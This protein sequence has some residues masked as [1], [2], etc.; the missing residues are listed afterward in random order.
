MATCDILSNCLPPTVRPSQSR[1]SS[2]FSPATRLLH[3]VTHLFT[4]HKGGKIAARSPSHARPRPRSPSRYAVAI[5]I[6]CLPSLLA[7]AAAAFTY[8]SKAERG[9]RV[10]SAHI[11]LARSLFPSNLRNLNL[12]GP[13][14][15]I[16]PSR[17]ALS[18]SLS[19][20]LLRSKLIALS[21]K[22]DTVNG[23]AGAGGRPSKQVH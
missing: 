18:L 9:L 1:P 3:T 19:P 15:M 6:V 20:S 17:L 23:R 8:L 4:F 13:G 14:K 5:A 21:S 22:F 12:E 10:R 7:A 16:S 2:C 11:C